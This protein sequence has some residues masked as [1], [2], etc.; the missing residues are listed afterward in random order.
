MAA[1]SA[2]VLWGILPIYWKT[3]RQVPSIEILAHRV[4]W[5]LLFVIFLLSIQRRWKEVK[6]ILSAYPG[7]RLFFISAFLLGVNWLIF[8]WAINSDQIVEASLGYFINPLVN[9]CLGVVFLRERLHKWQ[10]LAVGFALA[11]VLFLTLQYGRV[12]WIAFSLA[13]TFGIYGLLRKTARAESLVGLLLDTGI[14][15]PV[16]L[17]Y[18]ITLSGHK[19]GAF[20]AIDLQTDI[21]L[22]GAGVVT[23]TPLLLFTHGARRIQ[24]STV[25]ILQYIGP[26]G[27]LLVGVLLYREPFT[28]THLISFG[29]VW[30]GILVY[31]VSSL[32]NC[33]KRGSSQ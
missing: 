20:M 26:T 17:A 6:S 12:P 1:I 33:N 3:L 23:A 29:L 16:A 27:H 8:I 32:A 24:Y 10:I 14:L 31:S 28:R 4:V 13:F 15:T 22:A 25:G 5:S 18:L 2:L 7:A 19:S 11:G 21:L 9:V 30:V